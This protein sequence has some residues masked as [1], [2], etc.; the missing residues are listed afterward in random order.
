MK[1]LALIVSL[2]ATLANAKKPAP[3]P[4][5]ALID[6][7][8]KSVSSSKLHLP[9]HW[10][11]IY[12]HANNGNSA[13]VLNALK[14]EPPSALNGKILVIVGG[15]TAA[16]IAPLAKRYP[17]LQSVSWYAD[18]KRT[19]LAAM[20]LTGSPTVLGVKQD[21]VQWTL[22]GSLPDHARLTSILKSWKNK[23]N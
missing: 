10:L 19:A 14:D 8:G 9:S 5:F 7:D 1:R 6:A 15:A 4:D 23:S 12:V 2:L 22:T 11:L 16:D 21:T 18:P 3:L 17:H 20:H 13:V